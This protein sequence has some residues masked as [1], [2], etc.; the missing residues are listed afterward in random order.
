MT[1]RTPSAMGCETG[2]NHGEASLL[3]SISRRF[4][5]AVAAPGERLAALR[6]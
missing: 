1:R 3:I 2:K 4:C 5:K 6:T